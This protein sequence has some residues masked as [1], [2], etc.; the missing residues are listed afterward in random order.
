MTEYSRRVVVWVV[1][2]V[3][4]AMIILP[5]YFYFD[6]T[7]SLLAPKCTFH[8]LTGLDCPACGG[9]RALHSLLNG[10]VWLSFRYNPFLWLC[11]P[12]VVLLF[13]AILFRGVCARRLY[14]RLT[15]TAAIVTFLVLYLLWWVVRNLPA[16][17]AL[18]DLPK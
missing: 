8:M 17:H 11:V 14:D 7:H 12:Y 6:P 16:W 15:S 4:V 5:L 10:E 13:Y 3:F 2:A 18:V 9:Q 1:I